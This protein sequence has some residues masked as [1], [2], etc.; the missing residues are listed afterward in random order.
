MNRLRGTVV[1]G[2]LAAA[3]YAW[4]GSAGAAGFA[5]QTFGGEHGS[6]VET[7]PTAVYYNPGALGFSGNTSFGLYGALAV[8]SVT[9]THQQASDDYPDPPDA[10]GA[11]TGKASLLN[12]FGGASLGASTHLTKNLVIG[13]GFFAPFFGISHWDK[14]NAF[15]N[16]QKYPGA[17]D[18]VQRWFGTDG[19][20]EVLYFSASAAYRL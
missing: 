5:T 10:Q 13:G 4:Q 1:A 20:I 6:V 9:W 11:D 15:A 8:H 18:G 19:K 7:N 3:V 2:A 17:V 12:V 14:N 16:S